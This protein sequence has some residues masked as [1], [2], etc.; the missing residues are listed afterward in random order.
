M[1]GFNMADADCHYGDHHWA[2]RGN[3]ATCTN[4]HER[5]RCACGRFMRIDQLDAHIESGQCPTYN[6]YADV[7]EEDGGEES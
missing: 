7:H 2:E 3:G 6:K 4:C 5:F 1:Y